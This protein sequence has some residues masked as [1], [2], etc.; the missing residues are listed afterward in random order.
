MAAIYAARV[1]TPTAYGGNEFVTDIT[2]GEADLTDPRMMESL[3][4]MEELTEYIAD[5]FMA[6]DDADSQAL[7]YTE[8]AAM[9]VNGDF[10][11]EVLENSNPDLSIGVIPGFKEEG[12]DDPLV[13]NWWMVPMVLWK[14]QSMKKKL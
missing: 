3:D 12:S 6:L 4:R 2:E 14:V 5:G 8:E 10:Q 1:I 9:Y 7:F 13:M 11:L